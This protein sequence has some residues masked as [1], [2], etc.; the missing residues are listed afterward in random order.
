MRYTDKR[1]TLEFLEGRSALMDR[2]VRVFL[3]TAPGTLEKLAD[4]VGRGDT[5]G[6]LRLSHGLK[7]SAGMLCLE[8]LGRVCLELERA[9]RARETDRFAF[10]LA[11]VRVAFSGTEAELCGE[12]WV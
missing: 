12:D 7:N 5:G 9:A 4:A 3:Q 11:E 8:P 2:L 6:V 10:L 1:A